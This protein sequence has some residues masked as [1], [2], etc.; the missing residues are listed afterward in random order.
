M[1]SDVAYDHAPKDNS[2]RPS[3]SNR[4]SS[5]TSVKFDLVNY[6]GFDAQDILLM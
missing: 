1:V 4:K 6:S 2:D 5:F 3:S